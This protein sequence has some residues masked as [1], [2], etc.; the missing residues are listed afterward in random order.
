MIPKIVQKYVEKSF[1]LDQKF[2]PQL[3][4]LNVTS[5][6]M[7]DMRRSR[8]VSSLKDASV[9]SEQKDMRKFD[10][11]QWVYVNQFDPMNAFIYKKAYLRV[12]GAHF[13]LSKF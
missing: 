1:L 2:L 13:D 12:C 6:S 8:S 9:A 11:R 4:Q 3:P 10:L 7:S 5:K